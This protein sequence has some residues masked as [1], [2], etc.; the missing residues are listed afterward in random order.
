MNAWFCVKFTDYFG[1]EHEGHVWANSSEDAIRIAKK[2]F[3][4]PMTITF[5]DIDWDYR[6]FGG[7]Q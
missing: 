6:G 5:V 4:Y 2:S 7:F 1:F 3:D